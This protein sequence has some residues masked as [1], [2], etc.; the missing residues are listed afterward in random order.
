VVLPDHHHPEKAKEKQDLIMNTH[1]MS[2]GKPKEN[3]N[4]PKTKFSVGWY[5]RR[6]IHTPAHIKRHP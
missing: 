3:I 6:I 5:L 4:I 2:D 1:S